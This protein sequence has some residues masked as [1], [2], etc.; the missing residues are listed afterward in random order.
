MCMTSF[1]AK[2]L[3]RLYMYLT[4]P[5]SA[6]ADPGVLRPILAQSHNFVMIEYEIFSSHSPNSAD[7]R[8]VDVSY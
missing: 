1:S 6:I 5:C 4:G 8:R 7:S 3:S 2:I